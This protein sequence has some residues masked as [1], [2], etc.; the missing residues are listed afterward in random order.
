MKR[1]MAT[2]AL[3][4]AIASAQAQETAKTPAA[5]PCTAPEFGQLDFWVGDWD[6]EWKSMDGKSGKSRNKVERKHG[7]CVVVETYTDLSTDFNG[8]G[9][10]GYRP[11]SKRWTQTFMDNK[12]MLIQ[13]DGGPPADGKEAFVLDWRPIPGDARQARFVFQDVK[14]DSLVWKFQGRQTPASPWIDM[15]VSQYRRHK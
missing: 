10:Y 2:L 3:L 7:G 1:R 8:T 11:G 6:V 4:G 15:T 5:A 12:G 14:P 13:A 9:L